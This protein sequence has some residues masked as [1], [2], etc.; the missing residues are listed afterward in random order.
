MGSD[1]PRS[2]LSQDSC[3]SPTWV[4]IH[5]PDGGEVWEECY[6]PAFWKKLSPFNWMGWGEEILLLLGPIGANWKK[7]HEMMKIISSSS[8]SRILFCGGESLA[9]SGNG[10][11]LKLVKRKAS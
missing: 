5:D 1:A 3:G 11:N 9:F 6:T 10:Y 2:F 8:P 4:S 7:A